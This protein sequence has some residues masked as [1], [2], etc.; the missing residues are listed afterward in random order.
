MSI[1][2]WKYYNHAAVP[3]TAPHEEANIDA[4]NDGSV[5]KEL[6]PSPL[7]ARWHSDWDCGYETEWWFEIKDTAFDSSLLKSKR[8]YEINKGKKNYR[9]E[10]IDSTQYI[11][12]LFEVTEEAIKGWPQKYRPSISKES[13][14]NSIE[15][16][17]EC[18]VFGAFN[19]DNIIEGY[20]VVRDCGSYAEFAVLRAK[21]EAEKNAIN[22]AIVAG[23]MDY[24]SDRLE[25]DFYINDGSRSISHE[26]AFQEYL[27]KY[28]GFRKAYC[29]LHVKYRRG[30]G[31]VIKG[32]YPFRKLVKGNGVLGHRLSGI[33]KMEE[34]VRSFKE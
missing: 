1:K 8:R 33:L 17:N 7:L 10:T 5:W 16:W 2:G 22:A 23:I 25:G 14:N 28:F 15:R 13:F 30:F 3:T 9:V 27:E 20:A 18:D 21:P 34:I 12:E 29:K 24:Y 19:S 6:T 4:I 32:I 26:T 11:A 31:F